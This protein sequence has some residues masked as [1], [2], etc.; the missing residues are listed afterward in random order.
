MNLT[1]DIIPSHLK[2]LAFFIFFLYRTRLKRWKISN[3]YPP[4]WSSWHWQATISLVWMVYSCWKS[5]RFW[6][7]QTTWSSS[8]IT[9]SC[10]KLSYL[11]PSLTTHAHS[12]LI[13]GIFYHDQHHEMVAYFWYKSNAVESVIYDIAKSVYSLYLHRP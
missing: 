11:S 7:Y 5:S 8:W 12:S 4:A 6:M 1:S 10:P 3:V 2:P 9:S 13:T